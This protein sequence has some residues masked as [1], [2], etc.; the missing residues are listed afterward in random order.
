[1]SFDKNKY[2]PHLLAIVGFFILA[3][4]FC[5]P[6][7]DGK[8]LNQHDTVSWKGMSQEARAWHEKTGENTLWSNSMFGGMPTY[9]HYVPGVNNM[10]Y[11]FHDTI[12]GILGMPVAF[13]LLAMIGFYILMLTLR[14]NHWLAIG[15]SIAYAFATYNP[16]IISVGHNTKMFSIGYMP[17]VM[18]GLI[19][20]FRG[21]WWK[22]TPVLGISLALIISQGHYQVVYYLMLLVIITVIVLFVKALKEQKLKQF[23][24]ASAISLVAAAIAVGTCVA[25]ILPTYEYNKETMRG[26]QSELTI[27]DHDKDKK[28]GGLDKEYAFRWS[29]GLGETFVL[30]IPYL[31]GGSTNEPV[32]K[33]P[34]TAEIVGSQASHIPLYWGPQSKTGN[35]S[36]PM[37]FGAIICFLF[38]LGTMVVKS[39]HKWWIII[40]SAMSIMCAWGNHFA[41]LNYFMF[42]NFPVLNKF[43]TPSIWLVLAQMLFPVLAMMALN[44]VV[45][46]K[47]TKEELLKKLKIALGITIGLCLLLGV[48]GSMFFDYTSAMDSYFPEQILSAVRSDRASLATKSALISAVYIGLAGG[49]IWMYLKGSIQNR[50][51]V[52]IGITALI[53]IDMISVASNYLGEEHYIEESEYES[54]FQPR[55]VDQ[56][57]L[58]DKNPYYRVLDL[59]RSPYQDA[60]QAYFHK[61]VGGYH[62]AKMERYQDLIDIHMNGQFNAQVLNM[63]NTKYIIYQPE[64]QEPVVIPNPEASGNAWFVNRVKWVSSADS[65]ILSLNAHRL[66]D[67]AKAGEFDPLEV[68]VIRDGFKKDINDANIGKDSAAFVRLAKYGLNEI[69]FE[70]SNSRDGIAV[71][72]DMY[73]PYGWKAYV[74]GKETPIAKANYVLRAVKVPAG[75]HKIEFKFHPDTFYKGNTISLISSLLLVL[76]CGGAIFQS[77]RNR[78]QEDNK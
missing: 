26:G 14:V 53:A 69:S 4:L 22:G 16:E 21:D 8:V 74:D 36:G 39:N 43:R 71:F 38:V 61:C 33:A 29:I 75:Q 37:Y 42:D 40:G 58:Q 27:T 24:I 12:V 49:L 70:S 25:T 35:M 57:I 13:F 50:N 28:S 60:I 31:Y 73:Y 10:V 51:I 11:T 65:E 6:Q 1:M 41:A 32:E 62:P 72:S 30:M 19:M 20:V 55:P 47:Q 59:S 77:F 52:M 44:E 63:L 15:G 3:L 48:G 64:K 5:Y 54:Y 2:L 56:Q 46:G 67:S 7:L 78:K 68:A 66:G 34:E 76:I 9:T 17:M 23:L 45:N 18:A